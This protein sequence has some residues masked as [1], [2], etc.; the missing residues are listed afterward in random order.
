VSDRILILHLSDLH[1]GTGEMKAEDAK[2]TIR[3]AERRRL[4]ERLG[5]Y[6]RALPS[7]PHFVCVTGDITNR[8][9]SRGLADFLAWARPLMDEGVLPPPNRFL[10]T[11]GNHDVKRRAA[12]AEERFA[13]FYDVARAFPHAFIP[14]HD[15]RLSTTSFDATATSAGGMQVRERLGSVEV[16]S[17]QP[18]LYD[19][20]ARLLLFAFNSSLAC[21]TYS[22]ESAALISCIERALEMADG[23]SALSRHLETLRDQASE[24]LLLDAALVGEEQLLYF[25]QQMTAVRAALGSHWQRVTKIALLHHHVN[26]VW[27]QQL[28][29][30][31]F[32]CIIDAAQVKQSL[33]EFGFDAVLHGHKHQNGVSLDTTVVPTSEGRSSEPIGIV[34][35]GTVCG[36]PALNDRQ[37]FKVVILEGAG[38]RESAAVEEYELNDTADPATAMQT[39]RRVYRLPLAE[40]T[41]ELHD[42]TS[43]KTLLDAELLELVLAGLPAPVTRIDGGSTVLDG[44]TTLVAEKARYRFASMIE[45]EGQR[46]FVDIILASS[47]LDFRQRA[48]IHWMLVDVKQLAAIAPTP[49][50][51]LIIGNLADTHFG[52]ERVPGEIAAS[53]VELK[54]A[55]APALASGLLSISERSVDQELLDRLDSKIPAASRRSH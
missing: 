25:E 16:L 1:I 24:D 52:R 5:S 43:L 38:R 23:D 21:G 15:P 29:L 41:P 40:V 7:A 20:D 18:F 11:P 28:E 36:Q 4:I 44:D 17:S 32:E 10:I 37:T 26:P 3:S 31:P 34:S 55:F 22:E 6:L 48:R 51:L 49:S 47:R 33:T 14:G 27:R 42:D 45:V 46:L 9:D 39:E 53:I 35:G 30:K 8:G 54:K 19:R 13:A 12:D 2:L 50:V